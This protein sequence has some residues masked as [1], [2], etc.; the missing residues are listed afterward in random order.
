VSLIAITLL[1]LTQGAEK[2]LSTY[3]S[4][5]YSITEAK[6]FSHPV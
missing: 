3:N 6:F 2:Q 1:Q 4:I 5:N